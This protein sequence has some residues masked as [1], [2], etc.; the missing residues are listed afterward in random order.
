MIHIVLLIVI[1]LLIGLIG[2]QEYQNR[3]ERSRL[4]NALL[5]RNAQELRD[6]NMVEKLQIRTD[7]PKEPDFIPVE[8]M[9]EEQFQKFIGDEVA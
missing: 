8:N 2:W 6:L 4:V 1:T 3:Q 5:S 7:R 9:S